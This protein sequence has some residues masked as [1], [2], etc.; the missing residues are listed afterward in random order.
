VHYLAANTMAF[1][2]ANVFNFLAG[3]YLI[4]NKKSKL[5]KLFH[6]YVAV[7]LISVV[8]LLINNGA[9]YVSVDFAALHL[10]MGKVL[11]TLT[12]FL[13]NFGARKRWVYV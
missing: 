3:H 8:G 13:W 1:I 11:A 10:Y 4:F 2:T 6:T 9:L 5:K 7:L 12:A